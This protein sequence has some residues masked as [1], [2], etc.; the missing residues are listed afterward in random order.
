MGD[1]NPVVAKVTNDKGATMLSVKSLDRDGDRIKVVGSL[2]GAWDSEM[3]IEPEELLNVV[4]MVMNQPV[5]IKYV[6][7][8]PGIMK[9]REVEEL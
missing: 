7:D 2:L 9:A 3:F 1:K 5:I 6:L 8:L 4:Q